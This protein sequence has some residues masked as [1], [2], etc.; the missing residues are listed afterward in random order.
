[1]GGEDWAMW[2]DAL[3][4][5][6]LLAPGVNCSLF[7]YWTLINRGCIEKELLVVQKIILANGIC[8]R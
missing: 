5:E 6:N 7:L 2:I 8:Y 1:M 3:K 4:A